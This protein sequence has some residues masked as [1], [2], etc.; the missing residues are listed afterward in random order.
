[1][2][3]LKDLAQ[4][5]EQGDPDAQ[6]ALGEQYQMG[7]NIRQDDAEALKWYRKAATQGHARAYWGVGFMYDFGKGGVE[8]DDAEA[9][10]WYHQGALLGDP[11]CQGQL[12]EFY[13]TGRAVKRSY[14]QAYFWQLLSEKAAPGA[15]RH[16]GPA[17][18][19]HLS[20]Q[21]L[22]AIEKKVEE[23]LKEH[24]SPT[25]AHK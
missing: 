22:E 4:K 9:V 23:W 24:P 19:S 15:Y 14:H 25:S 17:P 8:K 20:T 3:E 7:Q 12:A 2:K 11:G 5:A 21:Q 16:G 18:A 1:M 10:K 13:S 6:W